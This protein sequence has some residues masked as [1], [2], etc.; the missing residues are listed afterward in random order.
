MDCKDVRHIMQERFDLGEPP[1]TGLGTHLTACWECSNCLNAMLDLDL[2]LRDL[3]EHEPSAAF[4]QRIRQCSREVAE[5][6]PAVWTPASGVGVALV[7]ALSLATGWLLPGRTQLAAWL[8]GLLDYL[9]QVRP[10][11]AYSALA[12]I[13]RGF[14]TESAERWATVSPAPA[15]AWAVAA[16]LAVAAAVFHF[17]LYQS[18][19]IHQDATP[20]ERRRAS[21]KG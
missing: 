14:W 8:S 12:N 11:L 17:Y 16:G 4:L 9:P 6:S 18:I 5:P 10:D 2:A 7:V 21:T 3:P 20:E 13:S 19:H 1:A 15:A